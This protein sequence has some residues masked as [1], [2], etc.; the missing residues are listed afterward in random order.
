M[1]KHYQRTICASLIC[2]LLCLAAA[3]CRET[4]M[5]P[6]TNL[7]TDSQTNSKA[8]SQADP[9][10]ENDAE[11]DVKEAVHESQSAAEEITGQSETAAMVT[12]PHADAEE[13]EGQWQAIVTFPDW[14]E[15]TDDTLAMNHMYSFFGYHGQGT[16]RI[17]PA[18]EVTG[19]SL[20]VND[21]PV[22]T[23]KLE[24]GGQYDLDISSLTRDGRNTIQISGIT[25]SDLAEAVT[26]CV[27]Y[28]E[29]LPGSAEEEGISTQALEMISDLISTDISH[30]F[31]SAQLAVIKDGR[32]V[33]E[34][35]WG[36]TNSYLP[37]GKV[38]DASPQ[39]TTE[40]LYDLASLTKMFSVNYAL[41]KL[42]TDDQIDLD[43]KI[44]DY[45]GEGFAEETV[46]VPNA[47]GEYP[48]ADLDEIKAWKWELTIRDL[49]RHQGGFPADPKYSSPFLYKEELA[50][51]ES[52]PENQ[53]FAGNI[54][55]EETRQATI[56][57]I[58]R[59][60]LWYEPGTKTLYSD[61]DYMI[62]GLV[63]EQVT[64]E[65]LD[66]W[67]KKTFWEPMDLKHI[68]Y[69]PLR[70]GFAKE[71][72]AATELNGNTRDNLLDFPGYRTYTLQGEVHDEKAFY[73][74]DG[75]SGH[76]GMFANASD[77]AKLAS[78]MFCGGYGQHR[79]FSQNVIDIFT[80]PKMEN[81]ADWGLG[82]WRQG[83]G[84]RIWYFG[85]QAGSDTIGH[86]GW[87]GTLVMIDPQ[88][89]LVVA[90]LTNK[91]N[92]RVTDV[93]KNANAFDGGWYTASTLGFVPQILYMGMDTDTDISSQLL[94]LSADM[95]LDSLKLIPEDLNEKVRQAGRHPA[96][97]NAQS[98]YELF[99]HMAGKY[100][101]QTRVASLRD[102]L[103]A[104]FGKAL[105][106]IP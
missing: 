68:T 96:V 36:K 13:A 29:I 73:G 104:A 91:I 30:G 1:V 20:Y 97:R 58:R 88:Q 2:I 38:N 84:Q 49:L 99:E 8:D 51:G 87:T 11:K 26:V 53:L 12:L 25:P 67:L 23:A 86:Q 94:D 17:C 57:M 103:R 55:G 60:P 105:I 61:V 41:Q 32:M 21:V 77:L 48:Q 37:D 63:V 76:A 80:A 78:V 89:N 74:M 56:D 40:T 18:A 54:P 59:T 64:G 85:T 33:Y 69:N 47:K 24:G 19:F 31:T 70:N 106:P 39:V 34:N 98:K 27:P 45:L 90:Y 62:L 43:A 44:A 95:A 83:D 82:W 93:K 65:S 102:G 16:L 66:T 22:D 52:Y 42:V 75:V 14:M 9:Q 50:E 92:S 10:T 46:L 7:S 5:N 3:G 79:F 100:E 71:D 101:D 81:A 28:P 35:A 6:S 72:C 15:Y 4:N